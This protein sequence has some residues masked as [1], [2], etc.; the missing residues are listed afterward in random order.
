[1]TVTKFNFPG[2]SCE[3]IMKL[4]WLTRKNAVENISLKV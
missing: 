1:M 4:R 3:N 2:K